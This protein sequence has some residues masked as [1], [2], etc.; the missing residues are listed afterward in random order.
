MVRPDHR[1]EPLRLSFFFSH[2]STCSK[3]RHQPCTG[4]DTPGRRLLPPLCQQH[5]RS[6]VRHLAAVL[7]HQ[8][9]LGQ[10]LCPA[11]TEEADRDHQWRA[12]SHGSVRRYF[13]S[14]VWRCAC[15]ASKHRCGAVGVFPLA[16]DVRWCHGGVVRPRARK[17]VC[18]PR[19][20]VR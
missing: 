8:L 14:H 15:A 5:T 19:C 13:R 17:D 2:S 6:H 10:H 20:N 11:H 4:L 7:H 3:R 16:G 12:K 1:H 9:W 18:T